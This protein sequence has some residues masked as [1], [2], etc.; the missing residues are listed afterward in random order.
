MIHFAEICLPA[1]WDWNSTAYDYCENGVVTP[2]AEE[3]TLD[4]GRHDLGLGAR[5]TV[6]AAGDVTDS[7]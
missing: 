5:V 4:S 3:A 7:I 6:S 2:R 1:S